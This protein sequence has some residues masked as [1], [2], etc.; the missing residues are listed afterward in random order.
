M[1]EIVEQ[2]LS[3]LH[4]MWRYRW[5]A[6]AMAGVISLA[7]WA[8]VIKLPDQYQ[9]T[10]RVFVDTR[11]MVRQL[12]AGLAT[13]TSNASTQLALMTRTLKSRP[14]LEKVARMTDLDL[15]AKTTEA[16]EELLNDLRDKIS[17]AGG[18]R[19]NLYAIAVWDEDPQVAKKIVQAVLT[20]FVENTLGETRQD[21]DTAHRFL[22]RQISE[23]EARLIAAENRV[24]EFKR[25]YVGQMPGEVGEY[26]RSLQKEEQ[27][28]EQ[29][30]LALRQAQNRRDALES[31]VRGEE[32]VFGLGPELPSFVRSVSLPVD[33]R[34]NALEQQLDGLLLRYTEKHPDVIAARETLGLLKKQ[35]EDEYAQYQAALARRSQQLGTALPGADTNPVYQ[36]LRIALAQEEANLASIETQVA[37]YEQRVEGLREMVHTIP[38]V[39]VKFKNLNRDY[40]ITKKNYEAL[41]ARRESARISQE[42]GQTTDDIRFRVIDPPTVP[43]EPSG[44]NRIRLMSL[45]LVAAVAIGFGLSFVLSQLRPTF[46]SRRT[47]MEVTNVPVFGSVTAV[48]SPLTLRRQRIGMVVYLSLALCLLAVY[49]GLLVMQVTGMRIL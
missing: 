40:D 25:K 26:Y 2:I 21:S 9:A 32:P 14:N 35:R 29:A 17:V 38:E 30:R 6:L 37:D 36:S 5:Y 19:D 42:A 11:S 47:L 33:A 41:L 22:D 45:V 4:A 34:I 16:M 31:Q 1:Q 44:P 10:A 23:Y 12:L 49:A 8:Y 48:I 15:K 46:D 3:Y 18:G 43:L 27:Q 20:I 24:K 39:E 7:G 28:L 13:N